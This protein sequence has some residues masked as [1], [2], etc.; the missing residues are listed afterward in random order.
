MND[1]QHTTQ[2]MKIM[3]DTCLN[4]QSLKMIRRHGSLLNY[5][6]QCIESEAMCQLNS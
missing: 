4:S 2:L 3:Y 5:L 1:A 6:Q